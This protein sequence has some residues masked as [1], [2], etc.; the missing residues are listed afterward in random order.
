VHYKPTPSPTRYYPTPSPVHY[1]PTPSPTRYYPTPSPVHYKPT[2]SPTRPHHEY[3][4]DDYS[5]RFYGDSEKDCDW[6]YD[7]GYC[8]YEWNH[9]HV[10]KKYCPK[11]CGY[12][13]DGPTP[14]PEP[15]HKPVYY[16]DPTHEPT[17]LPTYSYCKDD[18][19][20]RY[21]G[22]DWKDCHWVLEY[23]KCESSADGKHVGKE[24]CPKS[25]GYCDEYHPTPS[26]VKKPTHAPTPAPVYCQNH[27]E[28][29][30]H[31]YD[32]TDGTIIVTF[33]SCNPVAKDW[34]GIFH[35]DAKGLN[36]DTLLLWQF[37]CGG[38]H[39]ST[40]Y[41]HGRLFFDDWY[42]ALDEGKYVAYLF[43]DD[44]YEV[45]ATSDYFYVKDGYLCSASHRN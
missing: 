40:A 24:Y 19:D 5:D 15:T 26:P 44:S 18:N 29:E 22:D 28:V 13:H 2:P 6:V 43:K 38:Q 20:F 1:K 42:L 10:G 4:Y 36:G 37:T 14:T 12:C 7:N 9:E 45:K 3:C 35:E 31:C 21:W 23:G 25:C 27:V 32:D 34:V 16:P 8:D 17:P 41:E 11:S 33:T 39:C 30:E